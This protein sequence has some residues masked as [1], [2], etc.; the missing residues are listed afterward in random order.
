MLG[1]KICSPII[2]VVGGKN[3]I[4]KI[5]LNKSSI[6]EDLGFQDLI[7]VMTMLQQKC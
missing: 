1:L 4:K 5:N 2:S 6:D 7:D 3:K